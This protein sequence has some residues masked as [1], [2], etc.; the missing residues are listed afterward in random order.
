MGNNIEDNSIKLK[1]HKVIESL[2][3]IKSFIVLF[4]LL[5]IISFAFADKNYFY[6][7]GKI[8]GTVYVDASDG[9]RV[10]DYPSLKSNR[11]C[12]L[13]HRFPVKSVA[14]GAEET[15]DGITAPWVEILIPRYEWKGEEPEYGWIFGGYLSNKQPEFTCE[16]WT[17]K[18]LS[19]YLSTY[20]SWSFYDKY[21]ERI[22]F[23]HFNKD[24]SFS[25]IHPSNS[26]PGFFGYDWSDES[27]WY[28]TWN[29]LSGNSFYVSATESC[30]GEKRARTVTLERITDRWWTT[31][32]SSNSGAT[33]FTDSPVDGNAYFETAT[34]RDGSI[35]LSKGVYFEDTW[36]KVRLY[37]SYYNDE[38]YNPPKD[39]VMKYIKSGI[40]V[41]YELFDEYWDPII[42]NHQKKADEM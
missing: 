16:N 8:V 36:G 15:I 13:P 37:T 5:N 39:L 33:I 11:I 23:M 30:T 31:A 25:E 35:L 28:G 4:V 17:K 27:K 34:I 38:D 7:N 2:E 42:E 12:A 14:I 6:E 20:L 18:E 1:L 21:A 41:D 29:A 3:V 40:N 26:D 19:E 32:N 9:L 10:R 24:G 22:G